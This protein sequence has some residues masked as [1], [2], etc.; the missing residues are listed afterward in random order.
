MAVQAHSAI[1]DAGPGGYVAARV[2][3]MIH[4][5][6]T[7]AEGMMEAMEDVMDS[8]VHLIRKKAGT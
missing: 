3:G 7:L 5:C 4:T 2:A 6:P 8:A 1:L